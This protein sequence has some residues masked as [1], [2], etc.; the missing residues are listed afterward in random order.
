MNKPYIVCHMETSVDG[1]I[2]GKYLWL[3]QSSKRLCIGFI[4]IANRIYK[5]GAPKSSFFVRVHVLVL[6]LRACNFIRTKATSAYI[7]FFSFTVDYCS[8]S[9]NVR[10]PSFSC[11][12]V[13]V[14][15]VHTASCGFATY[16]TKV[17]HY[18]HLQA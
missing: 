14:R 17:C 3:P 6:F 11:A 8:Y 13:R 1:K 5:K 12:D 16:F 9:L 4:A 10:F 18:F 2:M 7:N 15:Y